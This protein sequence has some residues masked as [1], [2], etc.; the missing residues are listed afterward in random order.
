VLLEGR[1]QAAVVKGWWSESFH[2]A[3][4]VGE[5]G[6]LQVVQIL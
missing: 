3:A 2:Q 5:R 4:N 1:E 6:L